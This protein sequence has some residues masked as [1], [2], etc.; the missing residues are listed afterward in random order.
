[1]VGY[2]QLVITTGTT[3]VTDGVPIQNAQNR[4]GAAIQPSSMN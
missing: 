1:L 4:D 3:I 2:W